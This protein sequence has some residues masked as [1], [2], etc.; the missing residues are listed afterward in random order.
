MPD[1]QK[2]AIGSVFQDMTAGFERHRP[3]IVRMTVVFALLNAASN[4]LDIAGAAGTAISVGIL[5]LL[6]VTYGGMITALLC[7]PGSPGP[8]DSAG[9]LW[10]L[11]TPVLARLVWV[12]LIIAV[13]VLAGLMILIVPGLILLTIFAVATQVIVVERAGAFA[14][15]GRSAELV[16]GNGFKVFLFM[17]LLGLFF[18][19]LISLT[20]VVT[21]PLL[22]DGVAG[23]VVS[24]FLQN[25]IAGPVVAIGPAAL[26]NRLAHR[27]EP[28]TAAAPPEEL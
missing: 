20:V 11:V 16:R 2:L 3:L 15:L 27:T 26:Y 22:G 24:T 17:I 23:R 14:S 21:Y 12:T 7:V 18:L 1:A 19:L 6:S 9:K 5:L 25:L 4:L 10:S 8:D 13:A 28:E